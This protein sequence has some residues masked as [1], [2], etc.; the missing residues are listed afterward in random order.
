[1]IVSG[2]E[3]VSPREIEGVLFHHAGVL[4]KNLGKPY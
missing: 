3:N 1:M 2:G 4:E